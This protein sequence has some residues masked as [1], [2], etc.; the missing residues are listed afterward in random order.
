MIAVALA[1]LLVVSQPTIWS[2]VGGVFRNILGPVHTVEVFQWI[3]IQLH[4]KNQ[5]L[6][7]N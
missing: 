6:T 7:H 1:M 5:F 3:S 4:F 2:P